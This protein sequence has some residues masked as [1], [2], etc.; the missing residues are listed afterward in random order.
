M[1]NKPWPKHI[2]ATAIRMW[3]A[4]K[5]GSDIADAIGRSRHAVMGKLTRLALIGHCSEAEKVRRLA[6]AGP[7]MAR[8]MRMAWARLSPAQRAT[9][10]AAISAAAKARWRRAGL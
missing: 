10:V 6:S 9:W 4:G 7:R 5:T 8:G 1:P 3:R 2:E